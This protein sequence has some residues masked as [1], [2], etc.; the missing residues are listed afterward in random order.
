M[1]SVSMSK[2][3][4]ALVCMEMARGGAR[5]QCEALQ[6]AVRSLVK[7]HFDQMKNRASRKEQ[8]RAV[9]TAERSETA[10]GRAAQEKEGDME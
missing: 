4:A 8:P 9:A 1:N 7:R 3:E 6:I 5:E 2:A 10:E